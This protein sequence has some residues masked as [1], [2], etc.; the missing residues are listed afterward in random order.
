MDESFEYELL[1]DQFTY[2]TNKI[3]NVIDNIKYYK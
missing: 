2:M 3:P 1:N